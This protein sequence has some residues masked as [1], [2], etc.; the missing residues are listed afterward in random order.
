MDGRIV[1]GATYVFSRSGNDWAQSAKLV[2]G[3]AISPAQDNFGSSVALD[4]ERLVVGASNAHAT[5]GHGRQGAAYV[6]TRTKS[7]WIETAKLIASDRDDQDWFGGSLGVDRGTLVV[8]A[9]LAGISGNSDQGAAYVFEPYPSPDTQDVFVL[10][11]GRLR[12]PSARTRDGEPLFNLEGA[13]LPI[14]W[15]KWTD[16][17][18][19]SIARCD[20][21][22]TTV[23]ITLEGLVPNGV[24][25]LFYTTLG[26]DSENLSCPNIE[27]SLPLYAARPCMDGEQDLPYPFCNQPDAASFIADRYGR[28]L[29][30]ARVDG[31]LL[32]A[33][34]LSYQVVYHAD[35]QT[36]GD[37]PNRREFETQGPLCRDSWGTDAMRQLQILQK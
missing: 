19:E 6:F 35:G 23:L 25:S 36:Y 21:D 1:Q 16:P 10:E 27:R 26:P 31:C 7:T 33:V 9:P 15:D 22:R 17:R 4:G 14:T 37:L 11:D 5:G 12:N 20:N 32:D 2:A 29:F 3:D 34:Q 30:M 8:A 24:Y 13:P 28:M 18:G